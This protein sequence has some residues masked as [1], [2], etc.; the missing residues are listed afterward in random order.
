MVQASVAKLCFPA[1]LFQGD[2]EC[3]ERLSFQLLAFFEFDPING[4]V[5]LLAKIS[6]DF[7]QNRVDV[8]HFVVDTNCVLKQSS[9]VVRQT[10][11]EFCK[12]F[13]PLRL[14]QVSE[15]GVV[16]P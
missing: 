11:A 9:H 4:D 14:M 1:E 12:L 2:E 13:I 3:I 5:F 6:F 16:I 8:I 15:L 7:F 10:H